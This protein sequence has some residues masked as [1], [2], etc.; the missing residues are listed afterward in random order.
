MPYL[1]L[2]GHLQPAVDLIAANILLPI[3]VGALKRKE[4]LM[5]RNSLQ[6]IINL[7]E[8]KVL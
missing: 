4:F 1:L 7:N 2:P 6:P 5:G 3:L 8:E